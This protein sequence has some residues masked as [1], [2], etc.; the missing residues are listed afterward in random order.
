[1]NFEKKIPVFL[2]TIEAFT[3]DPFIN[4]YFDFLESLIIN[5]Y[6]VTIHR[7]G[8]GLDNPMQTIDEINHMRNFIKHYK[9]AIG[10]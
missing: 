4:P 6:V 7:N 8:H 5:G 9:K 1:M 10:M 2:E 3:F